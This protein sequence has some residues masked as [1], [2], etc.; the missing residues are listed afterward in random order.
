MV[1][2]DIDYE[3]K[4]NEDLSEF[5]IIRTNG[6]DLD[7]YLKQ[8]NKLQSSLKDLLKKAKREDVTDEDLFD[9]FLEFLTFAE[10]RAYQTGFKDGICLM[11]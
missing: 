5:I 3:E 9:T 7:E 10:I 8:E 6:Q 2:K 4:F 11:K 1:D